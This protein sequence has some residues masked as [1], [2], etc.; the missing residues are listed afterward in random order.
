MTQRVW[1]WRRKKGFAR[2][3]GP[4]RCS[5]EDANSAGVHDSGKPDR[6]RESERASER[7][8]ERERQRERERERER[9]RE[10][11]REC[12]RLLPFTICLKYY[13]I[14]VTLYTTDQSNSQAPKPETLTPPQR[15]ALTLRP[16]LNYTQAVKTQNHIPICTTQRLTA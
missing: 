2:K 3:T 10:R 13:L 4:A 14:T 11:E 12:I 16:A 6:E 1:T 9:D 5:H 8:S 15:Q 7:A